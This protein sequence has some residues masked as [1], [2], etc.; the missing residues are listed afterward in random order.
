MNVDN[1][2]RITAAT[3]KKGDAGSIT[4]DV[5]TLTLTGGGY[6][7]TSSEGSGKGGDLTV[8]ASESVFIS[9]FDSYGSSGLYSSASS[10]GEGGVIYITT[11]SLIMEDAA[12]IS[13]K[14]SGQGNAGNIAITVTDKF[15]M[16][17]SSVTTEAKQAD[18]GNIEISA[19][20]IIDLEGSQITS[21]VGQGFG[22][23]GNITIDPDFVILNGSKI[24]A[25]A[26]GGPG[27]I[28]E[29]WQIKCFWLI[30]IV[31]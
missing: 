15:L 5:G 2:G 18:G 29:L 6:I 11:P 24:I 30:L 4:L 13:A 25:N 28:S 16:H 9:G 3:K 19:N 26:Y 23:G 12:L 1:S 10:S 17:D 27:G 21:S 14:S 20:N 8:N 7:T 31:L 22:K